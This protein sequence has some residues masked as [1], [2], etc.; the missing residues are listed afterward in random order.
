M[1]QVAVNSSEI[2]QNYKEIK[3]SKILK[4][5]LRSLKK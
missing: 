2:L 1:G 3:A 4:E 5:I